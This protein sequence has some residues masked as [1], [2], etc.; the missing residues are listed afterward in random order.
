[1][2]QPP[3]TPTKYKISVQVVDKADNTSKIGSASVK[4]GDYDA[5]T[6]GVAGGKVDISNV[7]EGEY[8]VTISKEGYTTATDTIT[9]DSDHTDFVFELEE[10]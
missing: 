7:E 9:V 2:K 6:T 8:S 4:V 3:A 10:E 1:M 5:V